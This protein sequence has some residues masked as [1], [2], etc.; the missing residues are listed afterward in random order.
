MKKQRALPLCIQPDVPIPCERVLEMSVKAPGGIFSFLAALSFTFS[1]L[2]SDILII[3]VSLLFAYIFL[4]ITGAL[5]N[6]LWPGVEG[7]GAISLETIVFS[8]INVVTHAT[9]IARLLYDERA[10]RFD[11]EDEE[12]LWRFLYRRGGFERLEARHV[13]GRGKFRRVSE[14]GVL[15]SEAESSETLVLLIEGKALFCRR[16]I[17]VNRG[18]E[19]AQDVKGVLLSG[20][21]FDMR[22]TSIFGVYTGFEGVQTDSVKTFSATAMSDCLVFELPFEKLDELASRCGP[23][24]SSCF[25]N[26][27][28]CDVALQ[29]EYR[30]DGHAVCSTGVPEDE[31]YGEGAPS[32][33]FSEP[34]ED[35]TVPSLRSRIASFFRLFGDSFSWLVP[36]GTRHVGL[37]GLPR[38]GLAA[39]RRLRAKQQ[40]KERAHLLAAER[41]RLGGGSFLNRLSSRWK[42]S[43]RVIET[44]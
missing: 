30:M 24:V 43:P 7:D 4:L 40:A 28:L 33:D 17:R 31:A 25:R 37:R 26:L 41:A 32:R 10:I 13:I 15:L 39:S 36:S 6:P 22:L 9:A 18:N 23:A 11:G 1:S 19:D 35:N 14:G 8:A 29:L 16:Q 42:S 38:T 34:L 5:G 12:R 2:F 21:I 3:R 27:L 20:S 44:G